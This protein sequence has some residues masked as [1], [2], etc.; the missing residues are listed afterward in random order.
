MQ[1]DSQHPKV[2]LNVIS[3]TPGTF[4]STAT[5]ITLTLIGSNMMCGPRE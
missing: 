5:F 2:R 3:L 4:L 1:T